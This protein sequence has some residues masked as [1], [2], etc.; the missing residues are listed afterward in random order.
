MRPT[1]HFGE[2]DLVVVAFAH[3][4]PVD[5]Y[6]IIV[7]PVMRGFMTVANGAL[8]YLAFV[9]RKLQI[10]STTVNIKFRTQVFGA[11]GRAFNMPT[12]KTGAPRAGPAHDMF[13]R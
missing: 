1:K 2:P 5:G 7:Q 4:P 8:G 3:L 10:H 9:V 6:H 11:H 13:G 12:G